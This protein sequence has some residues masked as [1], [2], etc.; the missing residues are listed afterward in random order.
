MMSFIQDLA[1][2]ELPKIS[3]VCRFKK[4]TE[5]CYEAEEADYSGSATRFYFY[6]SGVVSEVILNTPAGFNWDDVKPNNAER[7]PQ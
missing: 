6:F 4:A 3:D 1:F 2:L 5:L 7:P